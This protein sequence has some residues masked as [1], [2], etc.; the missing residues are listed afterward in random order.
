MGGGNSMGAVYGFQ[1]EPV[2]KIETELVA[3]TC[4]A[5][6][7]ITKKMVPVSS[8]VRPWIVKGLLMVS[9]LNGEV[10]MTSL[11]MTAT[12]PGVTFVEGDVVRSS[13]SRPGQNG[14]L[15]AVRMSASPAKSIDLKT[16]FIDIAVLYLNA[17]QK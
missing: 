10:T 3:I 5:T 16:I 15:Q 1:F 7:L 9:L 13:A 12:S 11:L 17:M 8:W 4:S 14:R 6:S 2:S